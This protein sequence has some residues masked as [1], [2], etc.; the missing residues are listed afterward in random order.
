M[1]FKVI[2]GQGLGTIFQQS[3][4]QIRII[5]LFSS[6][7]QCILLCGCYGAPSCKYEQHDAIFGHSVKPLVNVTVPAVTVAKC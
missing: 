6:D 1:T 2:Q 5:N 3:F 7:L 4:S